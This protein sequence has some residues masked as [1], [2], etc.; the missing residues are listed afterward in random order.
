MPNSSEL[1]ASRL[2]D[3][4]LRW[5]DSCDQGQE[6]SPEELCAGCP[7]LVEALKRRGYRQRRTCPTLILASRLRRAVQV[8]RRPAAVVR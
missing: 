6:L 8:L 5:E 3:L 2:A 7:E 1:P 4:L